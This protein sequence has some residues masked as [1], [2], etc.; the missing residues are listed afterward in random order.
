MTNMLRQKGGGR[1]PLSGIL[2]AGLLIAAGLIM[3]LTG[4]QNPLNRVDA[5]ETDPGADL[6][7][8]TLSLS[9]TEGRAARTIMPD[10]IDFIRFDLDF[11]PGPDCNAG[12]S[13]LPTIEWEEDETYGTVELPVG[14]WDLTV[15]AFVTGPGG[16]PRAMAQGV[17]EGIAVQG[18]GTVQGNVMLA[19]VSPAGAFGTFRWHIRYDPDDIYFA[20]MTTTRLDI[21]GQTPQNHVFVGTGAGTQRDNPGNLSLPAGRYRVVFTLENHDGNIAVLSSILHI[22]RDMESFFEADFDDEHFQVSLLDIVLD[23]WDGYQ[24]NFADYRITARHLYLVGVYGVDGDNFAAIVDMLNEPAFAALVPANP[25]LPLLRQ[26]VDAALVG[27][28]SEDA[29]FLSADYENRFEVTDAIADLMGNDTAMTFVWTDYD[30]VRVRVTVGGSALE[31]YFALAQNI[32][33]E[34]VPGNTLAE[35]LAWLREDARS[36]GYYLVQIGAAFEDITPAQSSL[37]F[38]DRINITV[39]IRGTGANREIRLDQNG[40]MFSVGSGITLVLDSN[41]TLVGRNPGR[42]GMNNINTLVQVDNGGILRM[43]A[44]A[45]IM[46]NASTSGAGAGGVQ[47]VNGGVFI[48]NG[49]YIF[50]NTAT[51]E[52]GGGVLIES[53][54]KFDMLGGMIFDND[55]ELGGGILIRGGTFRMSGGQIFGSDAGAGLANISRGTGANASAAIFN[56]G[57]FLLGTFDGVGGFTELGTFIISDQTIHVINGVLQRPAMPSVGLAAQL[58]WLR[59]WAQGNNEYTVVLGRDEDIT[60]A[61]TALVFAGR[62]NVTVTLTGGATRREI[63][64]D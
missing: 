31:F 12:N 50:G 46:G 41:V 42:T 8:G 29:S 37:A 32:A 26:L 63:R 54:G 1:K 34:T 6:G 59:T 38:G 11:V 56:A 15:T 14:V 40:L 43:N 27:I 44:G 61:D 28:G 36:G 21:P 19:P 5:P 20:G 25:T 22:F 62:N 24:W 49:G 52:G 3:T 35:Q 53:G 17:L 10:A 51:W 47:V 45:N 39:R 16:I 9:I 23:T 33:P 48:L 2:G 13:A 55:G 30:T 57:T 4:C 7:T 18:G 60:P 58:A 64:L